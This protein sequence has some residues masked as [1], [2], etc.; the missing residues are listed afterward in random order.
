MEL[1]C[2]FPKR[3]DKEK[4]DLGNDEVCDACEAAVDL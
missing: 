3:F 4:F 2:K 1:V